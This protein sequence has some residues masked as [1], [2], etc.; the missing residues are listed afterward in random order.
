MLGQQTV[1]PGVAGVGAEWRGPHYWPLSDQESQ[2]WA[3]SGVAL[4]A[5]PCLHRLAWTWAAAAAAL[6]TAG[7]DMLRRKKADLAA[8][9]QIFIKAQ[10]VAGDSGCQSCVMQ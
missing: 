1:R 7:S 3:L 5:G 4:T 8:A 9:Q 6:A 10:L 2:G